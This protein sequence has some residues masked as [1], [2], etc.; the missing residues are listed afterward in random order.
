V[1][2]HLI[3]IDLAW[4]ERNRTGLAVLDGEGR[5][6]QLD[7]VRTDEQL[8]AGLAPF[9]CGDCVVAID[10]PLIVRNPTGNRPAEAALNRDFGPFQAGTHPSNTGRA[11]FHP[12]P[13]GERVARL[14][15]LPIS[16]DPACSR[17]AIEVY[18]HAA[19]ISLFRLGR[20]LKYKRKPGRTLD[21]LRAELTRLMRL[22]EGL[23]TADPPLRVEEL[24][25]W[26]TLT[27][28]V[29]HTTRKSGL[30]LVED[31]A[32]AVLCAYVALLAARRPDLSTTYGDDAQGFIVTPALPPDLTPT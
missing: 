6:V 32:D 28:S 23:S 2:V 5:L 3:G 12:M 14:L 25:A 31:Q 26:A 19:T 17:R 1:P 11:L 27:G 22:L 7:S 8:A 30:R 21:G 18:P 13:R 29:Q 9:V 24:A 15:G 4:G 20:T 16:V 10:A